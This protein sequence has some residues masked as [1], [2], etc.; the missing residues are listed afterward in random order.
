MAINV[1]S[2]SSMNS[3]SSIFKRRSW[4][5]LPYGRARRFWGTRRLILQHLDLPL[6][7]VANA[8]F[9]TGKRR[10]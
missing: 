2:V 1:L 3:P 6:V 8:S 9:L 10:Q 7:V 4:E 5:R